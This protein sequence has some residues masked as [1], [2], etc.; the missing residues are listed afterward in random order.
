MLE[1]LRVGYAGHHAQTGWAPQGGLL[2]SPQA[3]GPV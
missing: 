1:R 3:T 2:G